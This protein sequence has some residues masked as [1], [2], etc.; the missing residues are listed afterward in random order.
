MVAG[1]ESQRYDRIMTAQPAFTFSQIVQRWFSGEFETPSPIQ[2]AAWPRIQ[3][4]ESVLITAPTGSGKT[5]TAFLSAI[6]AFVSGVWQTGATRVLYVSPLKALNADIARN[7]RTPLAGIQAIARE[8]GIPIPEV[9][10]GVRS[11]DT[12]SS[13]RSRMVRRPPE[14]LITT[15]ES[16]NLI[17][18]SPQAR[19]ILTT[20]RTVILDEVHAIIGTKRGTH[21]LT[22]VE[23]LV[24]LAGEFQRIAISATVRPASVVAKAV[25]GRK[26]LGALGQEPAYEPRAMTVIEV[27]DSK[28][29]EIS[30][31]FPSTSE[32]EESPGFW[33]H[34]TRTLKNVIA[35]NTSTLIFV[36]SRR[37]AE[38]IAMLINQDESE[39]VAYSHHGSLSRELRQFV[40]EALKQGR[41]RAIVATNSLEL[42]IDVGALDAVVMVGTPPEVRSALQR[43][44]RAGHQVNATSRGL[45][46]PLHGRDTIDAAVMASQML[47]RSIEVT[48]LVQSPLDVLAQLI[49]SMAVVD[50]W[51]VDELFDAVRMSY[52]FAELDR[53]SF[54]LVIQMLA[55]RYAETRIRELS[56]RIVVDEVRGTLTA[57][58]SARLILYSSG[59]TIPDRGYFGLRL[60]DG[61]RVG[62]LDEEFVWE[63]RVG[64]T[65]S[66][67]SQNWTI[68]EISAKD[69]VVQPA[70]PNAPVIPFWRGMTRGR[71]PFFANRVLDWLETYVQAG[72][73]A[74]LPERV[75]NTAETFVSTLEH[76]LT[77][78]SAATGVPV[79]HRHH[80]VIERFP[81]QAAGG[82]TGRTHSDSSSDPGGE[83][84]VIHTLRGAMVNTPLAVALQAVIREETGVHL[85]LYATD[86]SIVAMVDERFSGDGLLTTAR[87]TTLLGHGATE[88]LL[89]SE[90]ESSSLF[91]ALFR[92]NAGRA[93][94]LPRSGFGKR[95]PLWLT[96]AR[97]RKIIE[98]VSRYSD[99]PILLETWRMCLQDVFAL[100][101]LRAFLESLVDGEIHV[102]ECTTTAPSPF[103]RTVVWQNTNVEMY[104]DDSR[105]GASASTLDQTALRALLHDQ[106]LRPRFSP[107]LITEVEARLQR[108]APGYS[109]KGSEELAAWID[110]RLILRGADLEALKAAVQRDHG[111][112]AWSLA[113]NYHRAV[114]LHTDVGPLLCSAGRLHL[115][116]R[117]IPDARATALSPTADWETAPESGA[118]VEEGRSAFAAVSDES[119][120]I[121]VA[122]AELARFFG[123]RPISFYVRAYGVQPDLLLQAVDELLEQEQL[124]SGRLS[125]DA[126]EEQVSDSQVLEYLL[127]ARRKRARPA[128]EPLPPL[129]LVP[130]WARRTGVLPV[131]TGPEDRSEHGSERLVALFDLLFGCPAPASVWETEILPARVPDYSPLLLDGLLAGSEL[132]WFGTS[133]TRLAF[134]LAEDLPLFTGRSRA[135]PAAGALATSGPLELS[136]YAA[137]RGHSTEDATFELWEGVWAGE[138]TNSGFESMRNGIQSRFTPPLREND[139]PGGRRRASRRRWAAS[140]PGSGTWAVLPGGL[141]TADE[142]TDPIDDLE[143]AK[144]LARILLGRYGVLFRSL[145]DRELDRVRWSTLFAALRI[146]ELSGE[147]ISGVFLR[148]LPS[149]QFTAPATLHELQAATAD[150]RVYALNATD[151]ASPCG[152]VPAAEGRGHPIRVPGSHVVYRGSE[153]LLVSRRNGRDLTIYTTPDDPDFPKL[154]APLRA[155]LQRRVD[156]QARISVETINGKPVR[157]SEFASALLAI[158]FRDEFR[159]FVL[160]ASY[161]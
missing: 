33:P 59:G 80:L 49:V 89:R 19:A 50:T 130:F 41:L 67:G 64:E 147:L 100:D 1:G 55:G 98:T 36:N 2:A 15:P 71:S 116:R 160:S 121:P 12:P 14:I 9:C 126:S 133:G 112:D 93:L 143:E 76:T 32:E 60:S 139:L 8:E 122:F 79:P 157:E 47:D 82:S 69:V 115:V 37:H 43:V 142:E 151:P 61:S 132:L 108:C 53:K 104:S 125:D 159:S 75:R 62:E 5:L 28:Q 154:F 7:L 25:G 81:S 24:L 58:P 96:R 120:G 10:V 146:M 152:V 161:R 134:C 103:A 153:L 106:G 145:F 102:S 97:S 150:R 26:P 13:E 63:R 128:I 148:G 72:L 30:L 77:T 124:I 156:R 31:E 51:G 6:D 105:P 149:P 40:E 87:A 140:R 107:S 22:A 90:L 113:G 73:Q 137:L 34:L 21:L 83:T 20:V 42:G 118:P 95:T 27:A 136:D 155:M 138:V 45:L 92:E 35:A 86:D 52:S 141:A 29:I 99:F 17:L 131:D 110:E 66:L 16:L 18:S 23:R 111:A 4:G 158:G 144:D 109:P 84:V 101:D 129:T 54:H 57:A 88:R 123:P 114:W 39:P 117:L 85:S 44:G 94:L 38:K 78:Q 46:V 135:S 119:A 68:L 70:R 3:S 56:P 48:R 65:F 11:G 91:G 74:A 127:R